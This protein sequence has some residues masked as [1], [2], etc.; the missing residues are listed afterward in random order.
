MKKISQKI[1]WWFVRYLQVQLFLSLAALPFIATKGLPFSPLAFVGNMLFNPIISLFLMVSSLYFFSILLHIPNS[2]LVFA[3]EKITAGMMWCLSWGSNE[4][5][6]SLP[7]PQSPWTQ[8]ALLITMF[9]VPLLIV[10]HVRSLRAVLLTNALLLIG[11]IAGLYLI[12]PSKE[13]L[14]IELTSK[15]QML[16]VQSKTYA[17]IAYIQ[18]FDND[19]LSCFRATNSWIAFTLIPTLRTQRGIS[20][21]DSVIVESTT[22]QSFKALTFL[23]QRMKVRRI[24]MPYFEPFTAKRDWRSYFEFKRAIKEYKVKVIRYKSLHQSTE[25]NANKNK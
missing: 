3:L 18:L 15:K 4:W 24:F 23:L 5:L 14:I 13:P 11:S 8:W 2:I 22:G 20:H 25:G 10:Q 12:K 19:A 6:I 16:A 1:Q 21:I 9:I 7:L 17:G